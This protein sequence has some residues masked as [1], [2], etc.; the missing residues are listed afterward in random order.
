MSNTVLHFLQS[1]HWQKFNEA[2][3]NDT[4]VREGTDY[5]Y[6][7]VVERGKWATRLYCPYGPSY[8]SADGLKAALLSLKTE[9]K[10]LGAMYIR[11]EPTVVL[12]QDLVR[13][14]QLV[15]AHKNM[16][17]GATI[18]NDVTTDE[19][20]IIAHASQTTR[21]TWRKNLKGDIAFKTSYDISDLS[22]FLDMTTSV[23]SRAGITQHT[24]EYFK[25]LA[26]TLFSGKH[27][28][29][30]FAHIADKP[31]A[32]ILFL[33]DKTTM[34]YSYAASYDEYRKNN[35]GTSLAMFGLLTAHRSGKKYFDFCGAAP[36]SAPKN[37]PWQGFT[38]FKTSFG[39]ERIEYGGTWELPI[40]K[41]RYR[42]Y[43]VILS[44]Y[45]HIR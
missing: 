7:A 5:S 1:T 36:K 16:Q 14:L 10:K 2:Q 35:V 21:W 45:T 25:T 29:L 42:L 31:A 33:Q 9:A 13:Q 39:G 40:Q 11:I 28:G 38:R 41:F 27:A 8:D 18:R 19:E 6:M 17:P 15:K 22:V 32:A 20:S 34:Y 12:D 44:L 43:R 3:G 26:K 23:A 30:L 24:P 4:I 37:H